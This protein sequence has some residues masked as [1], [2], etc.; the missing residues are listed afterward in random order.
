MILQNDDVTE[1]SLEIPEQLG[2]YKNLMALH[3]EGILKSLP[4]SIGQL[5]NLQFLSIP[6]NPNLK[7]IPEEV[8]LLPNLKVINIQ[9]NNQLQ[10]PE[11]VEKLAE[12]G[13]FISK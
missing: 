7:T 13:V 5:E 10:I 4:K 8:A 11:A 2:D 9:G 12:Q 6:N 1:L 3:F